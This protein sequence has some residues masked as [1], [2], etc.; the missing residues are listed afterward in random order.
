V[1]CPGF[2]ASVVPVREAPVPITRWGFLAMNQTSPSPPPDVAPRRASSPASSPATR[3]PRALAP[4]LARGAML[5]L[6][7]V[8][9]AV[10]VVFGGE[11]SGE[12]DPV[13]VE[14]LTNVVMFAGVH[15][16]AY[17]MFALLFGYGVVQLAT[18]QRAAGASAAQVR[19][20]LLRRN[21]W[22]VVFGFLHAALLYS[23]DFL[24]AYG[25]AGVVATLVLL[26]GGRR[27]EWAGL[28]LW[29]L[30][31]GYAAVLGLR[32]VAAIGA[33]QRDPRGLPAHPVESLTA[34]DYVSSLAARLAEWPAHTLAVAPFVV[35]V[36]LGMIAA[37]RRLLEDAAAH[38]RLL[39]IVA[40]TGIGVSV[41]GG[42]PLG[43]V[44]GGLL[45]LDDATLRLATTLHG[46]S[47]M[48]GGIGYT[49]VFGLVAARLTERREVLGTRTRTATRLLVALGRR[50]LSGY[51][52]QSVAWL[53]LLAPFTL[54]L[55]RR[56]PSP[57]LA[58]I[59][60]AAGVWL[61]SLWAADRL[62][63]RPGPAEKV[64]RRLTYG[65]RPA[66]GS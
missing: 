1:T 63:D 16:R 9:N 31:L 38:R 11:L 10:G 21:G 47:G 14:R 23:G 27:L 58:G 46:A 5:L 66:S 48:F 42:L 19:R 45:T 6:I 37:R 55:A 18:R 41:L 26:R 33:T 25:L 44:A 57:L 3:P 24:G 7:A 49:A 60:V 22:L 12:P 43:L 35:V 28:A 30:S 39:T 34:T 29:A 17:P 15:A 61:V 8:A 53:V 4:D 51:L 2:L 56:S 64:L 62:G 52:F 54:D 59:A 36:W 13:G 65:P 32:T 50:S 20:I 40:A